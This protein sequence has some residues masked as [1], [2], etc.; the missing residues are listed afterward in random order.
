MKIVMDRTLEFVLLLYTMYLSDTS[1]DTTP[2]KTM[3]KISANE[4]LR[5]EKF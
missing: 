1:K 3:H 4:L 2:Q 5:K